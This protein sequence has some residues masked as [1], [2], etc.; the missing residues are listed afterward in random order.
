VAVA[1][2]TSA[3]ELIAEAIDC[4]EPLPKVTPDEVKIAIVFPYA[5]FAVIVPFAVMLPDESIVAIVVLP[6]LKTNT[7]PDS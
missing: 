7:P 1:V 4:V 2:K 3:V 5:P 6:Y